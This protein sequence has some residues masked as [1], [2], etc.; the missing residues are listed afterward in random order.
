MSLEIYDDQPHDFQFLVKNKASE[1]AIQNT[2]DFFLGSSNDNVMS[3][4]TPD[5]ACIDIKDKFLAA[6]T[7]EKWDAWRGM[8]ERASIKERFDYIDHHCKLILNG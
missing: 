2:V 4:I 5:G 1:R 6:F 7:Q 3:R 8:L